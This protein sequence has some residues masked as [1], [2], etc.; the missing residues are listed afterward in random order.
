MH[1]MGSLLP[2][3]SPVALFW[4]AVATGVLQRRSGSATARTTFR[5]TNLA[6]GFS[7]SIAL[8]SAVQ[9]ALH[10]PST[11]ATLGAAGLGFSVRLDVLGAAAFLLI[12]AVGVI[13]NRFTRNYLDGD[14]RQSVFAAQLCLTLAAVTSLVLA[15]NVF[16]LVVAWIGTSFA[17]H[18]LLIFRTERPR[19]RVAA[20]KKF[21]A[22]RIGDLCV[23][24]A[25]TIMVA[26]FGTGDIATL[27]AKVD[28]ANATGGVLGPFHGCAI[29]LAV[30]ALLK[31]AQFPTHGWLIEVMETP[32]PVSAL[33]H[34]GI[35]NAGGFLAL[36]FADVLVASPA[37]LALLVVVGGSTAMFGSAAM[38]TQPAA[39]TQLAYSTV[40][41]MGFMLFEIGIGAF[42]LAL[43]HLVAHSLYKAHAFLRAGSAVE[44]VNRPNVPSPV[45]TPRR[46]LSARVQ[47]LA[48]VLVALAGTALVLRHPT[49]AAIA[50]LATIVALGAS[51][52]GGRLLAARPGP[53]GVALA[54][55]SGLALMAVYGVLERATVWLTTDGFPSPAD[56]TPSMPLLLTMLG[57]FA[58]LTAVQPLLRSASQ[59]TWLRV[60]Y[61]HLRNGLYVNTFLDRFFD[62]RS[63]P[64]RNQSIPTNETLRQLGA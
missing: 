11:S 59:P 30:A 2:L 47:V 52:L 39:K 42:S 63:I 24:G 13:V 20:R 40:A 55:G 35:V 4:A 8:V 31:S 38:L 6:C 50:T 10:G 17:L 34:A 43:L 12:S 61:V 33:L 22:A 51:S 46:R 3:A 9:V 49:H 48:P 62:A 54:L 14:P 41:Q 19:A 56:V 44:V 26:T 16:Q 29:L 36:R 32:T 57:A 58:A 60:A 5:I 15:G 27:A 25:A 64:T 23:V 45:P 18:Q 21:W 28:S 1:P 7:L 37:A 53:S